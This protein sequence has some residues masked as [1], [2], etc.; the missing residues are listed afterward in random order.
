MQQ[1]VAF[2]AGSVLSS[3]ENT[4]SQQQTAQALMALEK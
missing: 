3:I 2:R 1:A 4:V